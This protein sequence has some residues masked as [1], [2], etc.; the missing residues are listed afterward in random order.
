L[1]NSTLHLRD[2][3]VKSIVALNPMTSHLFG[4]TGLKNVT[5]PTLMLS[6]SEDAIT[7][8]LT[9]QLKPFAQL[10][11]EK[12]LLS[13]IGATHMSVTDINNIH[14]PLGQSTLGPELMGQDAEPLRSWVR[15]ATLAFL[16]QNTPEAKLYQPFLTPEYA[17]F[18]STPSLSFRLTQTIPPTVTPWLQGIDW[19]RQRFLVRDEGGRDRRQ[20]TQL[21]LNFPRLG[22]EEV[23]HQY[24]QGEL[25][26]IFTD[27][28]RSWG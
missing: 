20:D 10:S 22:K 26:E 2:R 18:L 4:E 17:Q 12:Y 9:N 28:S 6:S 23:T 19:T 11:G 1:P 3:R 15:G 13:A 5:I 21:D 8:T 24:Y 25:E 7:P 16:K 27:L 14:S